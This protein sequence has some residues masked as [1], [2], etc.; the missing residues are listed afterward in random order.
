MSI[1]PVSHPTPESEHQNDNR[2]TDQGHLSLTV[3]SIVRKRSGPRW[4]SG[5]DF[6]YRNDSEMIRI[7][8]LTRVVVF[9][10]FMLG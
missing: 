4:S 9:V 6:P 3:S 2:C 10:L 7:R 1:Q 5:E 8:S